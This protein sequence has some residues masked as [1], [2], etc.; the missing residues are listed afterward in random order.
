MPRYFFHVANDHCLVDDVG[1]E[2]DRAETAWEHAAAVARELLHNSD[3]DAYG[4]RR[5]AVADE[6][7]TVLFEIP[8][9]YP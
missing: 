1:E 9:Q 3:P 6:R 2:F 4:D 8:L 7:G 5:I